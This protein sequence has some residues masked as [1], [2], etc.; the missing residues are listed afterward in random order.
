MS[1][2]RI[3]K[4]APARPP[5]VGPDDLL[6]NGGSPE[7]IRSAPRLDRIERFAFGWRVT[8]GKTVIELQN[9]QES[10]S[11]GL[12][13][14]IQVWQGSECISLDTGFN[15][16]SSLV[17]ARFANIYQESLPH[18]QR[19]PYPWK[20]ALNKISVTIIEARRSLGQVI[21][22]NQY[23]CAEREEFLIRPLLPKDELTILF[24][25][26]AAG[27]SFLGLWLAMALTD[28]LPMPRP[29]QV[30]T[31]CKVLYLDW[32][33]KPATHTRRLRRLAKGCGGAV[34]DVMYVRMDQP[35]TTQVVNIKRQMD[36]EGIELIIHDSLSWAAGGDLNEN[37]VA[38]AYS[39]AIRELGGTHLA[40]AHVSSQSAR[41][42]GRDA[43]P[44]GS[45]FF[46][47]GPRALWYLQRSDDGQ[48]AL[49][50][51][52][53]N[54]DA[55]LMDPIGLAME[56]DPDNGPVRIYGCA[57]GDVPEFQPLLELK[58]RAARVLDEKGSMS[59]IAL[60]RI[61]ECNEQYLSRY[62]RKFPDLFSRTDPEGRGGRG[63][64]LAWS[65]T[66]AP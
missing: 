33:S 45:R 11:G 36:N 60:A 10:R 38:R 41:A 52:K 64:S 37:A 9:V 48:L 44:F 29:L 39:S 22:L 7:T 31:P 14:E 54:D 16:G 58:D 46:Y 18:P 47:N 63:R 2:T 12:Q 49:M 23:V 24:G 20:D 15:L 26:G 40:I 3:V 13:C 35:L 8:I 32:E 27:K 34:P 57:L 50:Q 55:K 51:R 5:K 59:N 4:A 66:S 25:D 28:N 43:T 30:E 42:A 61:L 65:L 62:M 1:A 19:F 17:R 56:W 6:A 53:A 21:H